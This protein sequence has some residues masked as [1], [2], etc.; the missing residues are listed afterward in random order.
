MATK[1]CLDIKN[2]QIKLL[3]DQIKTLYIEQ[4]KL[5]REMFL[6]RMQGEGFRVRMEQLITENAD[7][8]QK[9]NQALSDVHVS[10]QL[11]IN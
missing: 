9:L 11:T 7:L 5:E 3:Q 4:D 2:Y 10:E 1:E 6:D 8:K